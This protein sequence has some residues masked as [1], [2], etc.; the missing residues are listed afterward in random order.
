MTTLHL[1]PRSEKQAPDNPLQLDLWPLYHQMRTYEGLA[2]YDLVAN[3]YDTGTGKTQAALLHLLR[4]ARVGG[5]AL[6]IAPTNALL[7]QHAETVQ[8]FVAAHDLD[9]MVVEMN[10]GRLRQVMEKGERPGEALQHLINNPTAYGEALG[11][12]LD[13]AYQHPLVLVVNPDIFYYALFFRYR[14][15]DQRNMFQAFLTTFGYII[16]D[17][18]H[19]YDSKQLANFLFFFVLSKDFGYFEQ[20]RRICLLSATPGPEVMAYLDRV[21]Q[22]RWLLVAPENEPSESDDYPTL[23]VL[24][25]LDLHVESAEIQDWAA[26]HREDLH[27]R[28]DKQAAQDGVLISSALWRINQCY[29]ILRREIGDERVG[30]ITGPEPEERRGEV[31]GYPLILA[32]PTVDIGY[33]FRK[34]DK[35]RQNVD[36]LI[37][38]ARYRDEL[39]QRIGRAGR[40]LGKP[41]TDGVSEAVALLPDDACRAL[42]SYDE[43]TLTRQEFAQVLEDTAALPQRQLLDAYVRSYAVTECF[44][45]INQMW[46]MMPKEQQTKLDNL[47]ERV[48]E[49]FAPNSRRSA[50]GLRGFFSKHYYRQRW[51]ADNK[52][53]IKE[54]RDTAH[55]LSDMIYWRTRTKYG[56]ADLEPQLSEF[57]E[58]DE[59]VTQLRDFVR[60]QV[61]LVDALFSFRDSFQ[62]PVAVVYDRQRLLSSEQINAYNLIHLVSNYEI[63]WLDGRAEF[64]RNFE[65]EQRGDLYGIIRDWREPRLYV[66]LNYVYEGPRDGFE[67]I[68]CH[69]P[70]PLEGL[71]LTA[72]EQG[73]VPHQ[74][75]SRV[76]SVLRER[77]VPALIIKEE[78]RAIAYSRFRTSNIFLRRLDVRFPGAKERTYY[79]ILGTQAFMADA[80][81]QG[82]FHWQ[83][84]QEGDAII[85]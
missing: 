76:A 49:T 12:D 84:R 50:G 57:L 54:N 6:F 20:G 19:Y 24:T 37:C 4:L 41:E 80:E 9:Y 53:T 66:G 85:I 33:N 44:Y 28:L 83:E 68:W 73:D 58:S 22:D 36:F 77:C 81:L 27:D 38:D 82:W 70:V 1:L 75:D 43:Q 13:S 56:P 8:D 59:L 51:L 15:H 62:G 42:Q 45:P 35:R 10:A 25:R 17:E 30:R 71:S 21:F 16:I 60:G 79:V 65:T 48:R 2:D 40:V 39:V 26:G 52:T 74:L 11:S 7:H 46:R 63:D 18:F 55:Q 61:A 31:T 34:E 67:K 23:P 78:E 29:G 72:W 32:T 64:C 47:F 3:V 14:S 69:R 5:N